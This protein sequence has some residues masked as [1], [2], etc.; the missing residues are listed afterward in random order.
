LAALLSGCGPSAKAPVA[1]AP[2]VVAKNVAFLSPG[3]AL[4][5][6]CTPT[7]PEQC[8]N[9]IDDNCNGVIDEGCGEPTGVLQFVVAWGDSPADVDI[10]LTAPNKEKIQD[11]EA[12][13][14]TRSGFHLDKDCPN[15][16]C[17]DQ[18]FEDIYFDG[19]DPPKG[20]YTVDVK[21]VDLRT[22]ESPVKVRF[23]A[24]LGSRVF[25]ADLELTPAADKKT[26]GFDL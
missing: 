9:G 26:F 14:A 15:D 6:A 1:V 2:P 23:G 11:Q 12:H 22:A 21:L 4:V 7:A 8:F 13:R 10:A 18:N 19:P 20:H 17:G 3:V 24:R 25:G 16:P 5:A